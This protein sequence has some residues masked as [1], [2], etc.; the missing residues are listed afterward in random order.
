MRQPVKFPYHSSTKKGSPRPVPLGMF[1][2]ALDRWDEAV[3]G[4]LHGGVRE[5][6]I[7]PE[8]GQGG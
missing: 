2:G 3:T 8:L 5:N 1:I 7:D 4:L 6:L